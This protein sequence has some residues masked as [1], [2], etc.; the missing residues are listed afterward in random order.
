L[1]F[2]QT[3]KC[4][5]IIYIIDKTFKTPALR[6]SLDAADALVQS[7]KAELSKCRAEAAEHIRATCQW[8]SECAVTEE[9]GRLMLALK[10]IDGTQSGTLATETGKLSNY[11]AY[12]TLDRRSSFH[13]TVA[14]HCHSVAE[15]G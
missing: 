7:T 10:K 3:R 12:A 2:G 6:E 11:V 15:D 13:Q 1:C 4:L 8:H 9:L 14:P 5:I